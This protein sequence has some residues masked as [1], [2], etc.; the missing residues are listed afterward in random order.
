MHDSVKIRE[1][2]SLSKFI[3]TQRVMKHSLNAPQHQQP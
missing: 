1:V 3:Y 2:S